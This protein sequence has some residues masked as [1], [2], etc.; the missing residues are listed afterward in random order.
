MT[1]AD[2]LEA[3][4][5]RL[6]DREEIKALVARYGIV[7]DDRDIE[8]MPDLFTDDVHIRSLDGVMDSRGRDAAVELFKGRFEVLGPSN[9]FT[10]DKIIEFDENDPDSARGTVLSHAEMNRK[11]Q[12]MLAAIRYH[13]RYRRDAGKWRIAERVFSF[14]YYVATSEYLEALG[15]GLDQRMR[16][17]DEPMPADIP[18]KLDSWKRYYGS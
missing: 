14:F 16:A 12:P 8:G 13:D 6:E 9:H 10:H 11:G 4:V 5:Q 15:P 17:Y 3:R 1:T 18:E 2:S 7:M